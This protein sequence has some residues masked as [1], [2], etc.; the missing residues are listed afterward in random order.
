MLKN[1]GGS[2]YDKS[3]PPIG[4][5]INRRNSCQNEVGT[6]AMGEG[7]CGFRYR[8]S[9]VPGHSPAERSQ[10]TRGQTSVL[11][12][13]SPAGPSR[14]ESEGKVMVTVSSES[15]SPG[16]REGPRVEN[17]PGQRPEK[18]HCIYTIPILQMRALR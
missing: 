1:R 5:G 16:L 15:A 11:L 13:V 2:N 3:C 14:P 4:R 9:A 17:R 8:N 10:G 18:L 6:V 12:P 7:S